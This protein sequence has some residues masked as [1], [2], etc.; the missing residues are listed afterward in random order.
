MSILSHAADS[1][2][3]LGVYTKKKNL[4]NHV[5]ANRQLD[6]INTE[7]ILLHR[8]IFCFHV[9]S[10]RDL[11]VASAWFLISASRESGGGVQKSGWL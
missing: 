3:V 9:E 4:I 6:M 2:A 10:E 7:S 1:S 11:C 5:I 8:M